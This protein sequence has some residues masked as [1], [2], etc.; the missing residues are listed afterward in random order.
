[1][2]G[3]EGPRDIKE[4]VL[5]GQDLR[6]QPNDVDPLANLRKGAALM[7]VYLPMHDRPTLIRQDAKPFHDMNTKA[8]VEVEAAVEEIE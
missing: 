2:Y 8:K 6:R 3:V 7:G 4:E 5:V 1:M